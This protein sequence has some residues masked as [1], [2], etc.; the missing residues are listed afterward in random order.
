MV[1]FRLI[2]SPLVLY[3]TEIYQSCIYFRSYQPVAV[4][5]YLCTLH[6]EVRGCYT[7]WTTPPLASTNFTT[8]P[9]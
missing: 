4:D 9:N 8:L 5:L 7:V 6:N 1:L 2:G 3:F